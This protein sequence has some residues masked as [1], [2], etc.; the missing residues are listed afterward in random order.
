MKKDIQTLLLIGLLIFSGCNSTI[1][2]IILSKSKHKLNRPNIQNDDNYINDFIFICYLLGN[3]FLPH[4]PSIDIKKKGIETIL[5]AYADIYIEYNQKLIK[6]D[7]RINNDFLRDLLKILGTYEYDYFK[8]T[9]PEYKRYLRNK[10]F[11]PIITNT[12]YKQE[13]WYLE[14]MKLFETSDPIKLG[15]G[16]IELWKFRYFFYCR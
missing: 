2:E 1:N 6:N 7:L 15:I 8:Y 14:N 12:E 16:H 10:T 3:D 5:N 4:L 11:D 13:I 9:L